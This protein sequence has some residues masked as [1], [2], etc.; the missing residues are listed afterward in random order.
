MSIH[1]MENAARTEPAAP[2]SDPGWHEL[3]ALQQPEWRRHPAHLRTR[4]TLSGAEPLV[5][6]AEVSALRTSLARVA[7]GQA[8]VLQAGDCA[9]SFY[10]CVPH[11]VRAQLEMLD[12]LAD[13]LGSRTGQP[14]VRLGRIGGQFAKPRSQPTEQQGAVRLPSFR[15][16]IVNSEV[17]TRAARTH[18]PRRMLWAY[19]A[20]AHVTG[21]VAEH[22][23]R[24]EEATS[25]AASGP[26][27]SHEALLIDYEASLVR[28]DPATGRPFLASTHFPWIGERTRQP[29]H[30][31]VR[32]LA[33]VTNPVACKVGPTAGVAELL[34]LCA[35]LD[36]DRT[37]GRLT[38]IARMGAARVEEALPPLVAAVQRAGHPVIW[39]CDPMHGNTVTSAGGLKTRR[40]TD[41]VAEAAAFHRVLD[42][43]SVHPGGLHLE[44]TSEDVTEC[45]G[46][47]V[48]DETVLPRRYTTLCDP[49]ATL[50]QALELVDGCL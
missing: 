16:H 49:R 44:T 11:R 47:S 41:L 7:T 37:P 28:H 46:G 9:E 10:D 36:P 30:A 19:E 15:G 1:G 40:L 13:R 22:R 18:D 21:W 26:W 12:Q 14:V 31:H 20:S 3:P 48:Q 45:V 35:R 6:P 23:R 2:A 4:R 25:P 32:L 33:S 27:T 24:R 5:T 8:R 17:P 34:E 29:D 39:L 42:A 50:D 43:A 38:L